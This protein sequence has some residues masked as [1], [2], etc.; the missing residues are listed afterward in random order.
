MAIPEAFSPDNDGHNDKFYPMANNPGIRSIQSFEIFDRWGG[1]IY[2]VTNFP[3]SDPA[4]GWN[5]ATRNG[6]TVQPG[7]YV[8]QIVAEYVDGEILVHKGS[9]LLIR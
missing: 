3:I 1:I 9:F 8:Y 4:F 7:K 2:R 5:G 6:T